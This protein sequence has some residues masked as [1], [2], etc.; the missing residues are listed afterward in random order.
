[1]RFS[2]VASLTLAAQAAVA[3]P[4]ESTLFDKR[5][6]ESLDPNLY[7][8]LFDKLP[9]GSLGSIVKTFVNGEALLLYI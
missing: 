4:H 8:G 1:M 9:K 3:L 7:S 6:L 5:Q 2:S